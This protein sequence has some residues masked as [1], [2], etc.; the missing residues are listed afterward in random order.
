VHACEGVDAHA[1]EELFALDRLGVLDADTVLVHGLALDDAG[2]AL[3]RERGVSLIVCPSSNMF[4]FGQLPKR[5]C[6]DA[7]Q[8][9]SLGSDS[10]LTAAGTLLDEIRFAITAC[11][12]PA[13]TAYRMVTESPAAILRLKD[14]EGRIH[15]SGAADMI[16]LR[17]TGADAADRLRTLSA[18]DVEFV[19]IG[20]RIQLA[21][22]PIWKR[23]PPSAK[24]DMHPLCVENSIRW[25]RAPVEELLR[26]AEVVL[27]AGKVRVGGQAVRA[28]E[29]AQAVP[30]ASYEAVS[31]TAGSGTRFVR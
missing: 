5:S 17:D 22:G 15:L 18:A 2:L 3:M 11:S 27:G 1:R 14:G 7:I 31:L 28:P 29:Y 8:N 25:L 19:M 10:P 21:S 24:Q 12:L 9:V 23:L 16:G 6:F 20:G 26:K 30:A 13:E 4:L